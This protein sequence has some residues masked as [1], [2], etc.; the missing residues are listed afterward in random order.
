MIMSEARLNDLCYLGLKMIFFE[1][2]LGANPRECDVRICMDM[3]VPERMKGRG[4]EVA[5]LDPDEV[6]P[7]SHVI[8]YDVDTDKV[9][10]VIVEYVADHW[11]KQEPDAEG[12]VEFKT[13]AWPKIV[14]AVLAVPEDNCGA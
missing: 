11:V 12:L 7:S 13:N 4:I 1:P 5:I 10:E 9:L 2:V 8:Q 14:K 3:G 6:A